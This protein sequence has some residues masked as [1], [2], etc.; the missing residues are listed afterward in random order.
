MSKEI[1]LIVSLLQ[2]LSSELGFEFII[3]PEYGYAGRIKTRN[4]KILYFHSTHFDIN[5]LGASEIATDKAYASFFMHN[6]GYTIPEGKSF[7]SD[8]WCRK[9][10]SD[11]DISTALEYAHKL[12]YPL[13]V[14]PNSGSQGKGVEKVFTDEELRIALNNIFEKCGDKV[15]LVQK[16]VEGNDYRIVVLDNEIICA[17]RREPLS[18]TGDGISTIRD[19][20]HKKQREFV[21]RGRDTTISLDDLRIQ[22]KLYRQGL[23]LQSVVQDSVL[24]TLLD[25]ANLSSGGEAEDV[26][27]MLHTDYKKMAIQLAHD[28]GLK[29]CGID[30]ITPHAIHEKLQDYCVLEINAAPGLDYY[31]ERGE[32][33]KEIVKNLYKKM[34]GYMLEI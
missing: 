11:R 24:V 22:R 2:E 21:R 9:I 5:T 13:I 28:M 33:Q 31:A 14:K 17:Y 20:L 8:N 27:N 32:T 30:I 25:N 23:D 18:V 3:E 16:F 4:G 34:L 29:F 12:G 1:A 15:A 26:K 7:Y 10:K 6:L 19:L